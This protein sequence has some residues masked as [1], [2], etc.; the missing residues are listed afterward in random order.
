MDQNQ[1][2]LEGSDVNIWIRGLM[3]GCMKTRSFFS[4]SYKIL[5]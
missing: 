4:T 5:F 3:V 1:Q 2:V